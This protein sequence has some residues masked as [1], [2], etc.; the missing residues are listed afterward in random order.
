M[1]VYLCGGTFEGILSGV[2]HAWT[3]GRGHEDVRLEIRSQCFQREL[4]AEYVETE[5]QEEACGKMLEAIEKRLSPQI[6]EWVYT[7]SMS[8][9]KDRADKIYRFLAAAFRVGPGITDRL[10]MPEVHGIFELCRSV[11]NEDHYLTEF[12]RFSQG[13][14]GVLVGRVGP[15]NDVIAMTACH[16]ADRM[17]G[18][19][20]IIYDEPRKKAAVHRAGRG[21]F[22]TELSEFKSGGAG[23][24]FSGVGSL[25]ALLEGR[26]TREDYGRLWKAFFDSVAV[27]ERENPRC[28]R[29]RLPLRYRPY[30]TEFS[31]V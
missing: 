7:A 4:F 9:D 18:E 6:Y 30:M 10:Q 16:F 13:P 14:G 27:E 8:C 5:V 2:C 31:S 20:W 28:Q 1:T 24:D 23:E 19:N 21:W 29:N 22:V 17:P 12:I 25:F 15:K 3:S 26:E 11:R